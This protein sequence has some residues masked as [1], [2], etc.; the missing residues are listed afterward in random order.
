M[1]FRGMSFS[2]LN[3]P[4]QASSCMLYIDCIS[5]WMAAASGDTT[6]VIRSHIAK[7]LGS[8]SIRHR[9]DISESNRYL[10]DDSLCCLVC[11]HAI[12]NTK[13]TVD[14]PP[15]MHNLQIYNTAKP[16][17]DIM[18]QGGC[19]DIRGDMMA[20]TN[21]NIFRV[22]GHLCGEFTGPRWIPRTKA[23]DAELW[24]FLWSSTD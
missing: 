18:K 2:R 11:R 12:F 1:S 22:T 16:H 14:T 5:N 20:S 17:H 21:G 8:I 4:G 13:H 19:I 10:I 23:S 7:T 9:S 6:T 15:R 24:C 3:A